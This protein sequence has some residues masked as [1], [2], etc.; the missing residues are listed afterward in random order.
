VVA[1]GEVVP[2]WLPSA[3]PQHQAPI[4]AVERV[5]QRGIDAD[6]RRTTGEDERFGAVLTK[7][8]VQLGLEEAAVA[9]FANDNVALFR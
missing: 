8:R 2:D 5:P 1:A 9:V 3:I 7:D 4:V 6:A